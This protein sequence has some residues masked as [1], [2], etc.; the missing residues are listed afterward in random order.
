MV[1]KVKEV[2]KIRGKGYRVMKD[3][4][5]GAYVIEFQNP[6]SR[7]RDEFDKF[8]D[9]LVRLGFVPMEVNDGESKTYTYM[10]DDNIRVTLIYNEDENNIY[11]RKMII[12][13]T[14]PEHIG[15]LVKTLKSFEIGFKHVVAPMTH[16]VKVSGV[17]KGVDD[18]NNLEIY[19]NSC[20]KIGIRNR[21]EVEISDI[22]DSASQK[23]ELPKG[24]EVRY[25][26]GTL[27]ISIPHT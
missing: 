19:H 1:K 10:N 13:N 5:N 23:V 11:I 27:Y 25:S 17:L 15:E 8:T 20:V 9:F 3:D 26:D 21:K 14:V 22:C 4:E 16:I 7:P 2:L 6:V 24:S 12:G 18:N